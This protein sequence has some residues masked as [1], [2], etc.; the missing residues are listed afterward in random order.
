MNVSF[1]R[2]AMGKDEWLTPPEI[3]RALGDFDLDP[4][5]PIIRPWKTAKMHYTIQDDGLS[6]PWHG[7]VWCNPPYG[8][9]TGKWLKKLSDY[10]NGIALIFARTETGNSFRYIWPS[11]SAIMFLCGRLVFYHVDGTKPANS[12]GAPSCLIA[13]GFHNA[14]ALRNSG[15]NGKFLFIQKD[16]YFSKKG[17]DWHGRQFKAGRAQAGGIR[18]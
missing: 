1:E 9:E 13:Y 3:I 4:C 12:A 15:L 7:R 10:G 17:G 18:Q 8:S 14:E 11:A 5:A 16:S 2:V 6:K